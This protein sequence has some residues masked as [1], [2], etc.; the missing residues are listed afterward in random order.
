MVLRE[1]W[2]V[3]LLL[4]AIVKEVSV[5]TKITSARCI[6]RNDN[7][8]EITFLS[9]FSFVVFAFVE[10]FFYFICFHFSHLDENFSNCKTLILL[11]C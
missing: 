9:L 4:I 7:E 1:F 6:S 3:N 11:P 2:M 5:V 8:S 10:R